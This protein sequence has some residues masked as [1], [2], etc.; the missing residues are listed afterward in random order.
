MLYDGIGQGG[1]KTNRGFLQWDK[2]LKRG[3]LS[4]SEAHKKNPNFTKRE[5]TNKHGMMSKDERYRVN[6][7][8]R[9]TDE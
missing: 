8:H 5:Y 9:L 2:I 6:T 4:C 3:N 1:H 7:S